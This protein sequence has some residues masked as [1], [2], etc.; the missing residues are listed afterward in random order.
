MNQAAKLPVVA[1]TY[2]NA[3]M[4]MQGYGLLLLVPHSNEKMQWYLTV[5]VLILVAECA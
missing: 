1:G 3:K 4:H 2:Y 5:L